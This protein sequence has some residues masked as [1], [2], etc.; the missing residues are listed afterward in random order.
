M[1]SSP[2]SDRAREW[3]EPPS[4]LLILDEE[5]GEWKDVMSW[6]V[7]RDFTIGKHSYRINCEEEDVGEEDSFKGESSC[8]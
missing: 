6:G 4:T 8:H 7:D 1:Y 3:L 2:A 5:E